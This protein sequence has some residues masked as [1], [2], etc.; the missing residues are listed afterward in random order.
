MALMAQP[1]KHP[2]TG[3]YWIRRAVPKDIRTTY[4]K[5]EVKRSLKTK[6]LSEARSK[7]PHEYDRIT[8]EFEASRRT[9]E[10]QQKLASTNVFE[11]DRLSIRDINIL[12]ARYREAELQRMRQSK[13]LGI[14]DIAKYDLMAIRFNEWR[15]SDDE[16]AAA[17]ANHDS[18]E[19]S[20]TV[21]LDLNQELISTFGAIADKLVEDAG[22]IITRD[23]PDYKRLLTALKQSIPRL[24][25]D[26]IDLVYFT[27][28]EPDYSFAANAELTPAR[29]RQEP[30]SGTHKQPSAK[31]IRELFADY[32]EVTRRINSTRSKSVETTLSDYRITI[33]R[34]AEF[35]DNKSVAA[36]TKA[37]IAAFIDVLLT[38]P[39]RAKSDVRAMSLDK[40]AAHADAHGVP[41]LSPSTVKKQV[42]ALSAVFEF[43]CERELC[44]L[45]PVHG[46]TK[47]LSKAMVHRSG[48]DKQ[49]SAEDI[50][51]IFA[52]PIYTQD[53]RPPSG[54]YGEAVYWL[55]LLAY[56]TGA[57]AEELAQLHSKDVISIDGITYI[58]INDEA[59]DKSV[60]NRGSTR[61]VPLHNHV[62]ELGFINY[63]QSLGS[64]ARVFPKLT[65]GSGGKYAN[66]VSK[67]LGEHF[68]SDLGISSNIKPLHGFRHTF[69]TLARAQGISKELSDALT[70]HGK[71]GSTQLSRTV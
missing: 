44:T 36:V 14:Q 54:A 42:M 46:T 37:D 27:G 26:V 69:K 8:Q 53:Y 49:Y 22:Y 18:N 59:D 9:M 23:N 21:E 15:G 38:L 63:L 19:T 13:S 48:S 3:V 51:K 62:L 58:D 24:R 61:R 39:A 71:R 11:Q 12:A 55:P 47:R 6:N 33:E 34:F 20:A 65:L 50:T 30:S 29:T 60:K 43:A 64:E 28:T 1:Y 68:R 4:G 2:K 40:Q 32:C 70:G 45:N 5:T 56:Y 7:Y 52:S 16:A 10:R 17:L 31:S 41:K 57:R 67:W 66:R 35:S 25:Q